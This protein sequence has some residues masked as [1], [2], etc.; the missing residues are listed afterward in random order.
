M[1]DVQGISPN[2]GMLYASKYAFVKKIFYFGL[3]IFTTLT[4][5]CS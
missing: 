3:C 5:H 2:F 1:L 4:L